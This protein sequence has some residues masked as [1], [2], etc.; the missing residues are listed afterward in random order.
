M[1]NRPIFI[2][3]FDDE[4]FV[5]IKKIDF[6]WFPG[7]AVVQKQKS[8]KS[9]H[10]NFFEETGISNIL[11]ISSKSENIVG[12]NASAFNLKLSLDGLNATVESIYQG[13]KVFEKGGPY[14]DLY[15][16]SSIE[17]KKD[18]RIKESGNLIGFNING[19]EWSLAEDF[20]SWLYMNALLQNLDI[21][22]EILKYKA[23]TDIEFN[24]KKSYNC[25]AKSAAI[26]VSF[27]SR[28]MDIE[29]IKN[30]NKFKKIFKKR[31]TKDNQLDMF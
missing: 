30:I 10:Y 8:I 23:F 22:E 27:V 17:A 14:I 13:S 31:S 28:N 9:L 26:Y 11:E 24:P 20:Y 21:S 19:K 2:P 3:S 6:V 15:L 16:K 1:S 29:N 25:Q 5:S 7:F 12:I 4:S 18:I